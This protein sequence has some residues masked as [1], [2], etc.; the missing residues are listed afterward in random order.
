M[1]MEHY[2]VPGPTPCTGDTA[3]T[4]YT[5]ILA[6]MELK[7]EWKRW[8][9]SDPSLEEKKLGKQ[10]RNEGVRVTEK[11]WSGKASWRR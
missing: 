5:R 7:S 6:L 8:T 1:P 3:V 9:G 2:C 10:M 11:R 4:K